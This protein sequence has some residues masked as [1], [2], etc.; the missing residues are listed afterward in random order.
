M[1]PQPDRKFSTSASTD[2][3]QDMPD[4]EIGTHQRE[5]RPDPYASKQCAVQ[6]VRLV[7]LSWIAV[8]CCLANAGWKSNEKAIIP[9]GVSR[10][11]P[12]NAPWWEL[13]VLPEIGPAIARRIVDYRESKCS[14]GDG[15]VFR[16]LADL[17]AVPGVGPRTLKRIAPFLKMDAEE[18]STRAH[19]PIDHDR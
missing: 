8:A 14:E 12:N 11:D 16:S 9:L 13:T 4:R 17:D 6:T 19:S 3:L 18:A 2:A 15:F 10:I 5:A 1:K 7:L